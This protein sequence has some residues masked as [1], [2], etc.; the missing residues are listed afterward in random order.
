MF[1]KGEVNIYKE[2][3][4]L[5]QAATQ[6]LSSCLSVCLPEQ[7][8]IMLSKHFI[9]PHLLASSAQDDDFKEGKECAETQI[10]LCEFARLL[11][12]DVLHLLQQVAAV[13]NKA[14]YCV[15]NAEALFV[16]LGCRSALWKVITRCHGGIALEIVTTAA[17]LRRSI[18]KGKLLHEIMCDLSQPEASHA[19]K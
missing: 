16:K 5:A 3:L 10:S 19:V 18:I 4:W 14:I 12:K 17:S 2:S 13:T 9:V 1:D 15:R 8:K 6:S 11:D 7:G